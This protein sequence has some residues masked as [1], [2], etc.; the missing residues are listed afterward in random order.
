MNAAT[1]HFI[2]AHLHDDVTRLALHAK[3]TTEV[4]MSVALT[5]IEGY[6][7]ACVKLPTWCVAEGIEWPVRLSLEQCS[8]EPTALYKRDLLSSLGL[9]GAM[10]DLTGGLGVDFSFLAPGF[11]H[12][13]YVERNEQLCDLA[14]HNFPLL[15][16][17]HAHI[18]CADAIDML[19][20]MPPVDFLFLDPARR[21]ENG[22]KVVQLADCEPNVVR[23]HDLLL[24]KAPCVMLK[25]S[26]MIDINLLC[27]QLDNIEQIHVV[28]VQNECKE[29]VVVLR[30]DHAD[31]PS[32][33]CVNILPDGLHIDVFTSDEEQGTTPSWAVGIGTYLYEPNASLLKAGCYKLLSSR[34]GVEKLHPSTHLYTSCELNSQWH[35]RIFRVEQVYPFSKSGIRQISKTLT[36]ANIS[37]R[38][39]P[40][41]A[42]ALQLR[43]KLRDGGEHYLFGTQIGGQKVIIVATKYFLPD[44]RQAN[45]NR[46]PNKSNQTNLL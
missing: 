37:V 3:R 4:D 27:H 31:S 38:N 11:Q 7:L 30:C 28:A 32:I 40:L 20:Q 2:Q 24:Q 5:Q 36:Q 34:H 23:L 12:A 17:S 8:S 42:Q 13:T 25:L 22:R 44:D 1:I 16:L 21:D 15:Q 26:P 19:E 9:H 46:Y 43:L 35:G 39:F 41:T 18:V 29:V 14:R 45:H 33:H 6:Q 10:A